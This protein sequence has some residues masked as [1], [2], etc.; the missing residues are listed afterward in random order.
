MHTARTV[1]FKLGVTRDALEG[2]VV[3]I[4][5]I[6]APFVEIVNMPYAICYELDNS[7]ISPIRLKMDS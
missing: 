1:T 2:F 5:S 3:N 6:L 7:I 4:R